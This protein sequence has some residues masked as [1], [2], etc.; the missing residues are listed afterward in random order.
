M[1]FA[2]GKTKYARRGF[3]LGLAAA[4]VASACTPQID[5]RGY[6]PRGND[7]SR[8]QPGM[9]KSEV[10]AL[11]GSPST[12]ATISTEGDSYYY[13]ASKL[14]T[15]AFLTPVETDRRVFTI[16][17]DI[18]NRVVSTAT[19]GLKDGKVFNFNPNATVTKGKQLTIL[20]QLLMNAGRF[21][22][23]G[24]GGKGVWN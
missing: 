2:S 14:E 22:N 12:T 4:L 6:Q 5:Y 9:A 21:D 16:L 24:T 23:D 1:A 20:Q 18:E 3:L 8:V 19:Y 11:L 15:T 17:F 13:I 10:E 7:E